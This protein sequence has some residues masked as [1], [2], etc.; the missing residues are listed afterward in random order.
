MSIIISGGQGSEEKEYYA[1]YAAARYHF[2]GKK[3]V[4]FHT[5]EYTRDEAILIFNTF[6]K[7]FLS[8]SVSGES[9]PDFY[10]A[11]G[12]STAYFKRM[13]LMGVAKQEEL[14]TNVDGSTVAISVE[15]VSSKEGVLDLVTEGDWDVVFLDGSSRVYPSIFNLSN[16]SEPNPD[17]RDFLN[18]VKTRTSS[19]VF[20]TTPNIGRG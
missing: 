16:L 2:E 20:Y 4:F 18:D 1:F 7:V 13:I 19:V 11:V 15:P 8:A 17:L 12:R 14:L 6:F 5:N 3:S 10:D 9:I